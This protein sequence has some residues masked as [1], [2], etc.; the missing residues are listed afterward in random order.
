ML[1]AALSYMQSVCQPRLRLFHYFLANKSAKF[2]Q[3]DVSE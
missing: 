3:F 2:R 1:T